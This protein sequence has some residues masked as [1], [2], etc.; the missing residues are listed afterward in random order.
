M[1]VVYCDANHLVYNLG[2]MVLFWKEQSP[3]LAWHNP[4]PS[5]AGD[6]QEHSGEADLASA[7]VHD[8]F[9]QLGQL[10]LASWDVGA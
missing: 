9:H 6:M 5:V 7:D 4:Q 3:G 2:V 8:K 1:G 10:G